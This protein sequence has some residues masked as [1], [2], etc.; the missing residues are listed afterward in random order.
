[1]LDKGLIHCFYLIL[2]LGIQPL[3]AQMEE[4]P[5]PG[6]NLHINQFY[7][8]ASFY[9]GVDGRDIRVSIKEFP[10]DSADID[11]KSRYFNSHLEQGTTTTHAGLMATL[12]GGAGIAEAQALGAAPACWVTSTG[13][14]NLNPESISWYRNQN[15]QVQNHSYGFYIDPRY[16]AAARD[17]DRTTEAVNTL[18]HVF[19]AGNKGDSSAITGKYA[20]LKGFSNLSGAFKMA[21]NVLVVGAIDS[22]GQVPVFSSK[23]PT[24]DGR[25]K[26][27]LVAFGHDGSSGAAAL[28]SGTAALLQQVYRDLWDTLPPSDWVRAILLN[29][30]VD[31]GPLGPDYAAGFGNLN[32]KRSLDNAVHQRYVVAMVSNGESQVFPLS[33][34]PLMRELKIALAWNDPS[35]TENAP[36]AL[37]NDLDMTL[38][39]PSGLVLYPWVLSSAPHLDSLSVPARRG[40]DTLNNVEQITLQLPQ[41]GMYQITVKGARVGLSP[42]TF[43][44]AF[45]GDTLGHF[46][47]IYPLKNSDAPAKTEVILRWEQALDDSLVSLEWKPVTAQDWLPLLSDISLPKGWVRCILPEYFGASQLRL[48]GSGQAYMSDTFLISKAL[49]IKIGYNC[50]DSVYF[51]WNP[52]AANANYQVYG[53]GDQNMKPIL[54]TQDTFLLLSKLDFPQKR[55]AVAPTDPR[56]ILGA[57]SAAPDINTQGVGCYIATFNAVQNVSGGTELRLD[58]GTYSGVKSVYIEKEKEGIFMP[59]ADWYDPVQISFTALD[60]KIDQGANVYRA[61]VMRYDQYQIISDT[62]TVWSTGTS[63]VLLFPNPSSRFEGLSVLLK[64]TEVSDLFLYDVSGKLMATY[65]LTE[66]LTPLDLRDWSPGVYFFQLQRNGIVLETGK[67]VVG[68]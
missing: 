48:L 23:G 67:L 63:A 43:A 15:I 25:I 20:N 11:L 21:K 45:D 39:D 7:R 17:Y 32:A 42:Q 53:L 57:R 14:N 59:L 10:F 49:Q 35:A 4:Q 2:I 36:T 30:A 22:L 40:R 58:L 5:V 46:D 55:F 9:P 26:P 38:T 16:S 52:A 19:S 12:V 37:L 54:V 29:S 66:T 28:V 18:V 13:F 47:W 44:L 65:T 68:K 56:G 62:I 24:Y 3:L 34:P 50:I 27:D 33:V 51:Y 1:M 60:Q 64:E 61:R 31:I 6:Q 8:A 41:T